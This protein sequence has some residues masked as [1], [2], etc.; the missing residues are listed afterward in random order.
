MPY[1]LIPLKDAFMRCRYSEWMLHWGSEKENENK[2]YNKMKI[3]RVK[4]FY[5]KEGKKFFKSKQ[6]KKMW[7]KVTSPHNVPIIEK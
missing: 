7:N 4:K 1:F 6:P 5:V 3:F 2:C